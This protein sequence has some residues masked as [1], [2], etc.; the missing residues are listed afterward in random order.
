[1]QSAGIQATLQRIRDNKLFELF[2][3]GVIILSSVAIGVKTYPLSATAQNLLEVLDYAVTLFFL[4]E[5]LIRLAA[6][7]KW[8]DF[9]RDLCTS[10][11]RAKNEKKFSLSRRETQVIA[12]YC[13]VFQQRYGKFWP[14]LAV[15]PSRAKVSFKKGWN[16]FGKFCTMKGRM[17]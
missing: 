9:F 16:I 17:R 8:L 12:S 5:I 2:V 13:Q 14:F 7:P 4:V 10:G 11:M 1:M 6:E 15:E 3:I